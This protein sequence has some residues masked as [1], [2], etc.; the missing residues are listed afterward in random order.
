MHTPPCPSRENAARRQA[1][2]PGAGARG[3]HCIA[4]GRNIGGQ[5][6]GRGQADDKLCGRDC[7]GPAIYLSGISKTLYKAHRLCGALSSRTQDSIARGDMPTPPSQIPCG[8]LLKCKIQSLLWTR[9]LLPPRAPPTAW[10]LLA[11][12][13]TP[14]GI[15]TQARKH[16]LCPC[17]ARP[18]P[19]LPTPGP[20]TPSQ[21][22]LDV[23]IRSQ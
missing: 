11:T 17:P 15:T 8:V 21:P 22:I 6:A 14:G 10:W 19:A 12:R 9:D 20:L 5:R 18:C 13:R 16:G 1:S 2:R 7:Y 4:Q 3:R 23:L